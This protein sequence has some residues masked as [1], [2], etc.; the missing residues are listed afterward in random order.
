LIEHRTATSQTNR[1]T[2]LFILSNYWRWV[3]LVL[4]QNRVVEEKNQSGFRFTLAPGM[5]LVGQERV[6][7]SVAAAVSQSAVM[8]PIIGRLNL[9][10]GKTTRW[11]SSYDG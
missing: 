6:S 3:D 7:V 2:K 1:E 10:S 11:E 4:R 5:S 9:M 8:R